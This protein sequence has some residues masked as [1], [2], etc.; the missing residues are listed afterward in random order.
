MKE[1][2]QGSMAFEKDKFLRYVEDVKHMKTYCG[3]ECRN[4]ARLFSMIDCVWVKTARPTG[5]IAA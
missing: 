1:K 3:A 2:H 5:D 4:E